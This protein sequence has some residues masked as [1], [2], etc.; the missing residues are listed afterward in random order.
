MLCHSNGPSNKVGPE[1][2]GLIGR[3]SGSVPGYSYSDANK[4]SGIIWIEDDFAK[5]IMNPRGVVPGTKMAFAGRQDRSVE[6]IDS[7]PSGM[8][9]PTA[10]I[11]KQLLQ[12]PFD[13]FPAFTRTDT[14][15]VFL[16]GFSASATSGS[17]EKTTP[18]E[19]S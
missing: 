18:V 13:F 15:R 2:N 19:A 14:S 7:T 8:A 6:R 10:S 17:S 11:F 3:Y 9:R 16:A 12:T 1:L 5:Y 4:N